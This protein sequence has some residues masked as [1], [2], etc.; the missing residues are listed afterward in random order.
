MH[1]HFR[2]V[3]YTSSEDV[4]G[5]RLASIS[6]NDQRPTGDLHLFTIHISAVKRCQ[7]PHTE[8]YRVRRRTFPHPVYINVPLVASS[9]LRFHVT[10]AKG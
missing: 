9:P 4:H 10:L 7:P 5:H 3:T 1:Q 8:V 6:M 2:L